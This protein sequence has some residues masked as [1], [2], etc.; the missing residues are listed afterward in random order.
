[1]QGPCGQSVMVISLV[2]ISHQGQLLADIEAWFGNFSAFKDQFTQ[3]A[4]QLFGSGYVWLC[5]DED[6]RLSITSTH[7]QVQLVPTC[8]VN[9][10][11]QYKI[12]H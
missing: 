7:N 6:E 2:H 10:H 11:K 3:A 9:K 4:A 1:M 5:E 8:L 12:N